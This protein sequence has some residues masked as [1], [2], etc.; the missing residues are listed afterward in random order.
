MNTNEP[1]NTDPTTDEEWL[2]QRWA[3]WCPEGER[4]DYLDDLKSQLQQ[5][6][7]KQA[8]AGEGNREN[9]C[10]SSLKALEETLAEESERMRAAYRRAG[11]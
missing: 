8:P 4:Q 10:R 1:K 2:K 3:P 5:S 7:Q 6:R 9:L 11:L